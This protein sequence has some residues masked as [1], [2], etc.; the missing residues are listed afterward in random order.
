MFTP[1][2]NLTEGRELQ[3]GQI[4]G[5]AESQEEASAL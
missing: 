1:S 4:I 5:Y 3:V 2:D